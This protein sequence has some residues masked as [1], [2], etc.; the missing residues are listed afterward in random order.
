V[1]LLKQVLDELERLI[2]TLQQRQLV[3]LL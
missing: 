3:L 2:G 1:V